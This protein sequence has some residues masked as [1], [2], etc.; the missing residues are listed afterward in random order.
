MKLHL[1]CGQYQRED[2]LIDGSGADRRQLSP[3]IAAR[4]GTGAR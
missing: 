1:G 2:D 4:R 3:L